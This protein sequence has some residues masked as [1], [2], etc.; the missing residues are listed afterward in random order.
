[1]TKDKARKRVVRA[2]MAKTGERYTSARINV[3]RPAVANP[4]MSNEAIRRGS[5]KSWA[6]WYRILDAWG[7][8]ER[9]HTEIARHVRDVLGVDGWWSQA[10]TVGYER[11]RGMRA[12]HQQ[13]DGFRVSVSR[14]LPVSAEQL[15]QAF[16]EPRVR[17][18]WLEKGTLRVRTSLP[19]RSARFDVEGGRTRLLANFTSKGPKRASVQLE[20]QRLD[21]AQAVEDMRAFWRERLAALAE[22]LSEG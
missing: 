16:V 2:R 22:T 7:A 13:A 12:R 19:F 18:R 21:D 6:E 3:A 8:D 4:G 20:H 14:T 11:A 17:N 9:T 5:G 1:M 10:V 15:F